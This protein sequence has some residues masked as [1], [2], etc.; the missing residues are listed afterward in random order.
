MSILPTLVPQPKAG[1]QDKFLCADQTWK[2]AN[3]KDYFL[4]ASGFWLQGNE[5][6]DFLKGNATWG[7]MDLG[8][9]IPQTQAEFDKLSWEQVNELAERCSSQGPD[10]FKNM[11]GF[12]KSM[13]VLY[14]DA[15]S[16]WGEV[17]P[18][19]IEYRLV[20]LYAYDLGTSSGK[21]GFTF[22]T[23][24]VSPNTQPMYN[25][26]GQPILWPD[27]TVRKQLASADY[28][29][30]YYAFVSSDVYT[31][32]VK[33]VKIPYASPTNSNISYSTDKLFIPSLIEINGS[34][35]YG[36]DGSRFLYFQQNTSAS[37][38]ILRSYSDNT[39]RNWWTRTPQFRSPTY[40]FGVFTDAGASTGNYDQTQQL[41]YPACFCL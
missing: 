20:D 26:S 35:T 15:N 24:C 2:E 30:G 29:Y 12:T 38:R 13:D 31:N 7:R 27:T 33:S 11:V 25:F 8:V 34:T 17:V 41:Y 3:S 18:K 40:R 36:T 23:T 39:A 37:L 10:A 14:K 21:S 4:A 5:N 6:I 1:D 22:M 32:Y 28:M 16:W 19:V 9:K